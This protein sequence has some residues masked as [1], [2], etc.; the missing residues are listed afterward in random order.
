M[1]CVDSL[2]DDHEAAVRATVDGL[3]QEAARVAVALGEAERALQH[4]SITR[5]MLAAV[6]AGHG[7]VAEPAQG[8]VWRVRA[9]RRPGP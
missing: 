2:L 1:V 8:T 6:L 5:A 9:G 7:A 4:V 3:R